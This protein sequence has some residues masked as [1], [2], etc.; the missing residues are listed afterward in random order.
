M[1]IRSTPCFSADITSHKS[2]VVIIAIVTLVTSVHTKI[3]F[4]DHFICHYNSGFTY[5]NCLIFI[6]V[7]RY[8]YTDY[9]TGSNRLKLILC[10]V[11]KG[12]CRIHLISHLSYTG[13]SFSHFTTYGPRGFG[14]TLKCIKTQAMKLLLFFL[15]VAVYPNVIQGVED[16]FHLLLLILNVLFYQISL[17]VI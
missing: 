5:L 13:L 17:V 6:L 15:I 1:L 10:V 9:Y 16:H 8:S 12:Q 11:R 7:M 14:K 2:P 3:V 4:I